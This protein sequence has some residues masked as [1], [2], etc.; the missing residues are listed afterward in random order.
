MAVS[1]N[2]AYT[3][4]IPSREHAAQA[5][6]YGMASG[7]HTDKFK[8][9]GLTPV[10]SETVD[11]PYVGEFPL[12]LECTVI[13]TLE[14]GLHTQFVGEIVNILADEAI[15]ND[16]GQVLMDKAAPFVYG[17]GTREYWAL[18]EAFGRGFSIGKKYR[19]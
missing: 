6:Y 11:A 7:K 14:I 19:K 15:L 17:T 10:P 18:G 12:I 9:T 3:I 16:Q 2:G 1:S 5:D 8:D 4:S 13:H